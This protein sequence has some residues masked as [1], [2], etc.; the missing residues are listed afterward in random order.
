ML[1]VFSTEACAPHIPGTSQ[2]AAFTVSNCSWKCAF[3]IVNDLGCLS[4]TSGSLE[5]IWLAGMASSQRPKVNIRW[6]PTQKLP[7]EFTILFT[8][9]AAASG[10]E[11]ASKLIASVRSYTSFCKG[12]GRSPTRTSFASYIV[13]ST[14]SVM[15]FNLTLLLLLG[16]NSNCLRAGGLRGRSSSPGRIKSYFFPPSRPHRLSGPPS[17]LSNGYG[18][19]FPRG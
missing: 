9:T 11:K 8:I 16:R 13:I 12:H 15:P 7:N 18:W 17:I 10:V 1:R 6:W 5:G 4:Y 14:S 2:W 3:V 19:L